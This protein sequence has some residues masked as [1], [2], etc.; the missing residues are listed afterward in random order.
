MYAK[1]SVAVGS[2]LLC[3]LA[4]KAMVAYKVGQAIAWSVPIQGTTGFG[5]TWAAAGILLFWLYSNY[6][7]NASWK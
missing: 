5:I 4:L 3:Y 7:I 2:G 1:I 6:K